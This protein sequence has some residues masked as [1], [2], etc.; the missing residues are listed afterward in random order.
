MT[1]AI[2]VVYSLLTRRA[3]HMCASRGRGTKR[4]SRFWGARAG[5][6]CSKRVAF[7]VEDNT[8]MASN[9]EVSAMDLSIACVT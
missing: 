6:I 7:R 4:M 5:G 2:E 8:D 3:L 9:E 1:A